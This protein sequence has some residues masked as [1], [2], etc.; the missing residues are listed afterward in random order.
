M[1]PL[2]VLADDLTGA[3][4]I[5]GIGVDF[6]LR[7]KV[8]R[9]PEAFENTDLLVMDTDS[10][11]L[12]AVAAAARVVEF[13]QPWVTSGRSRHVIYKK[14]DSVLRGRIGPELEAAR[15]ELKLRRALLVAQ[16][17]SKDRVITAG[18]KYLVKNVPLDQTTFRSDPEYPRTSSLAETLV[19]QDSADENVA[20]H[21]AVAG[22]NE[23][24]DGVII[25]SAESLSEV[26]SWAGG[27]DEETLPAG[28]ADFFQKV[29]V[30]HT[31]VRCSARNV[32]LMGKRGLIVCGSTSDY[33]RK[34]VSDLGNAGWAIRRGGPAVSGA[35]GKRDC[36]AVVRGGAACNGGTRSRGNGDSA[37]DH[38]GTGSH[39]ATLH[40]R[41]SSC[42][43]RTR[44]SGLMR[45]AVMA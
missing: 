11:G 17:P 10:R 19:K 31:S 7:A 6:G 44:T 20:I 35:L 36:G 32:Q 25:G 9:K 5:A 28:G 1:K 15:R 12:G 38:A 3:A 39:A 45:A 33:S 14:T 37:G 40:G 29:L 13:L 43:D 26:E 21:L 2:V 8:V 24:E 41:G 18:G 23:L 16:N 30:R 34:M 42:H 27:I 22:A 4:E